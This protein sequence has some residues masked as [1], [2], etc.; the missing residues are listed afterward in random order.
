[1]SLAGILENLQQRLGNDRDTEFDEC[2][3]QVFRIARL[4]LDARLTED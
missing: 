2:L 4:R 3:R 1:M